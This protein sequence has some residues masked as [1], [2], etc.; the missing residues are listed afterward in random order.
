VPGARWAVAGLTLLVLAGCATA[1]RIEEG[2]FHSPKGYRVTLPGGAWTMMEDG[3]AD[4]QLRHRDGR[5]GIAVNAGCGADRARGP[6]DVLARHLLSGFRDR[7]VIV[8]EDLSV[9]GKVARHTVVE[10]RLGD[11]G[12]RTTVE[13]YVLRDDR[14]LYDFLYAAPRETFEAG[15]ADFERLVHTLATGD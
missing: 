3:R 4:L 8:R 15:R 11:G 9:N 14:C 5:A 7:S 6:L 13:V 12:E 1:A 10:G 2:V